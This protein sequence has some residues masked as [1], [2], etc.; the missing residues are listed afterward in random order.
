[1]QIMEGDIIRTIRENAEYFGHYHTG[2]NPGRH[3]IDDTQEIYYPA[4]MKAI[5]D[6]GYQGFV[7]QEFVPTGDD[8]LGSLARCVRICDV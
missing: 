4:V 8:P 6:T 3:E 2:G 1:M 7:G 5:V